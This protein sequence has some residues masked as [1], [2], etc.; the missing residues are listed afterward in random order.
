VTGSK[1]LSEQCKIEEQPVR[2]GQ[3]Q[4]RTDLEIQEAGTPSS[5]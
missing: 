2:C 4:Y 1:D 3:V 5:F